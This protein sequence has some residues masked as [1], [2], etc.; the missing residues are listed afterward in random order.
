[1]KQEQTVSIWRESSAG[2]GANEWLGDGWKNKH[3]FYT[4][5]NTAPFFFK[6]DDTEDGSYE[7]RHFKEAH[8]GTRT[9]LDLVKRK[10]KR[11]Y[12]TPGGSFWKSSHIFVFV[13]E[14]L[15]GP[16]MDPS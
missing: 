12:L 4:K 15:I 6:N 2:L 3:Q 7:M 1:M 14:P 9:M 11:H 13:Q 16:S 10:K 8:C 5:L